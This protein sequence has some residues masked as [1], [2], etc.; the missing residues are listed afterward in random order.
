MTLPAATA[1]AATGPRPAIRRP[2]KSAVARG[3]CALEM[4][5]GEGGSKDER[6]GDGCGVDDDVD[7]PTVRPAKR[8]RF[9]GCAEGVSVAPPS[10]EQSTLMAFHSA[11]SHPLGVR[12]AGNRVL[13]DG[14]A[15]RA[16][17]L[18]AAQ[19]M[20]AALDD[21]F[22]VTQ[23]LT[24]PDALPDAAVLRLMRSCRAMY[25]LCSHD[26]IWRARTLRRFAGDFG[27]FATCWLDTFRAAVRRS[28]GAPPAEA[29]DGAPLPPRLRV[30]GFY[31]DFLFSAWR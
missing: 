13:D 28:E 23:L 22:L 29:L 26:D 12:P 25:V 21:G 18:R 30:A 10:I 2:A 16:T 1:T 9:A 17:R 6:E 24:D 27:P 11:V 7:K 19:G 15:E 3:G 4:T 31:S 5:N 8:V 14:G 20:L